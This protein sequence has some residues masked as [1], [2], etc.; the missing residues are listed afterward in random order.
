MEHRNRLLKPVTTRAAT[1]LFIVRRLYLFLAGLLRLHQRQSHHRLPLQHRLPR[2][3]TLRLDPTALIASAPTSRGLGSTGSVPAALCSK[4]TTFN[5]LRTGDVIRA[6]T[7]ITDPIAASVLRKTFLA[8][9]AT[10]ETA[11]IVFVFPILCRRR[12]PPPGGGGGGG[13]PPYSCTPY[14]WVL[15][16]CQPVGETDWNCTQVAMWEAGCW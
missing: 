10:F 15:Y 4:L 12:P 14:Y 5:F 8:I 2:L 1:S 6:H 9:Q 11:L 16:D 3:A 13:E 7:P